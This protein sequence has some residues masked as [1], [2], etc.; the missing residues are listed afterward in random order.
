MFHVKHGSP[1]PGG[2]PRRRTSRSTE[3]LRGCDQTPVGRSPRHSRSPRSVCRARVDA[4]SP[5]PR[6]GHASAGDAATTSSGGSA[7]SAADVQ[8][9]PNHPPDFDPARPSAQPPRPSSDERWRH[10]GP[11][12]PASSAPG[13]GFEAA[14][15]GPVVGASNS[16][17]RRGTS[18]HLPRR[19]GRTLVGG[20]RLRA[21]ARRARCSAAHLSGRSDLDGLSGAAVAQ[22]PLCL[23]PGPRP[24]WGSLPFRERDRRVPPWPARCGPFAG[25]ACSPVDLGGGGRQLHPQH[26]P[27]GWVLP[28]RSLCGCVGPRRPRCRY[29]LTSGQRGGLADD[30][31]RVTGAGPS[32]STT[33]TPARSMV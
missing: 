29:G 2:S 26:S 17:T 20:P 1:P 18:S 14:D 8:V 28:C 6:Y 24:G 25:G 16:K 19:V 32:C 23:C 7:Q 9:R 27:E 22:R 21:C 15:R 30:R 13:T 10:P 31:L 4:P 5:R 12:R 33:P 11:V 3:A